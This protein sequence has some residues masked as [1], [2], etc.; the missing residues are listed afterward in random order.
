MLTTLV[1]LA[2]LAP[3]LL[4]VFGHRF[5]EL[6]ARIGHG[7]LLGGSA[8]SEVVA[9][10]VRSDDGTPQPLVAVL[11][12]ALLAAALT[13]WARWLDPQPGTEPRRSQ[14]TALLPWLAVVGVPALILALLGTLSG[15]ALEPQLFVALWTAGVA[16]SALGRRRRRA[17]LPWERSLTGLP[18]AA[19]KTDHILRFVMLL[20]PLLILSAAAVL[21]EEE[22]SAAA[23]LRGLEQRVG[24][25]PASL[26][27]F[28]ALAILVGLVL[29]APTRRALSLMVWEPWLAALLGALLGALATQRP[30]DGEFL[31]AVCALSA[32]IAL[33]GSALGAAG[34]AV[35]PL[36]SPHPLRA[37]GRLALPLLAALGTAAYT[38][39]T[40]LLGCDAVRADPRIEL[41]LSHNG[42]VS[43]APSEGVHPALFVAFPSEGLVTR[44]SFKGGT[45]RGVDIN[46][47]PTE[48]L[49]PVLTGLRLEA[50]LLSSASDEE[51]LLLASPQAGPPGADSELGYGVGIA[52]DSLT[53]L[54]LDTAVTVDSC[55]PGSWAWHP[56]HSLGLVGCRD[57]GEVAMY[58]P[59]LHRFIAQQSI[60]SVPDA[61]SLLV[62]PIDGSL[63]LL[64]RTGSPF[65]VRYDLTSS[66]TLAW[67]FVGAGNHDL[68]QDI[69]GDLYLPRFLSRQVLVLAGEELLPA[70]SLAAGP[71]L[72]LARPVLSTDTLLAVSA[73]NGALYAL[74]MAGEQEPRQLRLGGLVRDLRISADG[75]RAF[76]AGMCGVLAIDLDA[77]LDDGG[78]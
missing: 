19:W 62:D 69:D 4:D 75:S 7:L 26:I 20:A 17:S 38:V 60:P 10:G 51:V 9:A 37:A 30:G 57:R 31:A 61:S 22:G 25:D 53:S 1:V 8:C 32:A 67:R 65:L 3:V 15:A 40:G 56:Y 44:L 64:P 23:L 12:A 55:D 16:G 50:K 5:T 59:T 76:A 66:S 45:D 11:A 48:I 63:L 6:G 70:R 35:L 78:L 43:L 49:D 42:A 46:R 39:S 68:A 14:R 52:I 27:L 13:L 47:L 58:E 73:L 74:D 29:A 34:A 28:T 54:P 71:G 77:W 33:A 24:G 18:A 72:V 2:V 41:L 36:L 21:I